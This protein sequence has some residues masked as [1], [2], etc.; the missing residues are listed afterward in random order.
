MYINPYN[1]LLYAI[2]PPG[3]ISRLSINANMLLFQ[4]GKTALYIHPF[5]ALK[6]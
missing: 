2:S 1:K 4:E 6:V 3:V 5:A